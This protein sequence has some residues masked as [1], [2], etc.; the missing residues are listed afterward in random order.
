MSKLDRLALKVF[1]TRRLLNAP[2]C[3]AVGLQIKDSFYLGIV[4]KRHR[5]SIPTATLIMGAKL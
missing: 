1:C 5:T 3:P 2:N 4:V